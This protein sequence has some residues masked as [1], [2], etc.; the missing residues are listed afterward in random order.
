[1]EF[2]GKEALQGELSK[3]EGNVKNEGKGTKKFIEG[4]GKENE[5]GKNEG[6]PMAQPP[7]YEEKNNEDKDVINQFSLFSP[8]LPFVD[9]LPCSIYEGK[10]DRSGMYAELSF[11]PSIVKDVLQQEPEKVS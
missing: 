11:L 4:K 1:L 10:R 9:I 5:E 8:A 6:N 3:F 2:L 7:E